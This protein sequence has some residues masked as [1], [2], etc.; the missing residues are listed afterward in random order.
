MNDEQPKTH[1]LAVRILVIVGG[2]ALL[3]AMVTDFF[4][5]I[6]RHT[7]LPVLGSIELV[8][9][10]VLVSASAAIVAAT[11]AKSHAVVHLMIDRASPFLRDKLLRGN[12]LLSALFFA[13]IVSGSIWIASDMW[14]G[15]EESELL[16]IPLAP[17]RIISIICSIATTLIFLVQA[18][19]RKSS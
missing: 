2:G 17:L 6:G 18:L 8:Q 12:R 13:A 19:G 1:S 15:H 14:Y 5:V 16:G 3:G 4:A 7:G 9:A 11:L 10:F